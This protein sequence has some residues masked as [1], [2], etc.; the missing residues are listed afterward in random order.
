MK[1]QLQKVLEKIIIPHYV[2]VEDVYVSPIGMTDDYLQVKYFIN[3]KMS[4]GKVHDIFT[5]TTTLW[6]ML[7]PDEKSDLFITFDNLSDG[8][9][10]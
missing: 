1:D 9:D 4:N 5:E 7:S 8:P 10:V 2:E 3:Q 6:K